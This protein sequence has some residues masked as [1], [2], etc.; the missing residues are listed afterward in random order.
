MP[1]S[2]DGKM[3]LAVTSI[4]CTMEIGIFPADE[5]PCYLAEKAEYAL[6]LPAMIFT[7]QGAIRFLNQVVMSGLIKVEEY[8]HDFLWPYKAEVVFAIRGKKD[9]PLPMLATSQVSKQRYG[10]NLPQS[11]NPFARPSADDVEKFGVKRIRRPDII[12]V[13]DE[14]LRWPGRNATYFDGSVHPDNLKMLIEVKF[15][16]D[17]L[18]EDQEKDY[19]QIA[20]RSRF[21]VMRVDDNRTEEQKQY[22]EVWR[23]FYQPGSQHYKNPVILPPLLPGSHPEEDLP[24]PESPEEGVPGTIPQ[25]LTKNI[26][27]VS[28]SPWSF[29]PSYE[30]WVI[31]GQEVAGLAE[32][33]LDYIRNS[34]RELLAQFGSWFSEA[35]KWVC[36][37]I[38]DPV[39]H[40][41]SYAFSWV[42]E[43]TGKIVTWT[44][45]EIK[46]QWQTVQ[47]GSDIT[48]EELKNIS[49]MQILKEVGEGMLEVVVIIASVAVVILVT[50]AVA[51]AL[52]ALVEILAT[53]ATVSAAALAAVLAILASV[54]FATAS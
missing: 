46:A 1:M 48:L 17:K 18:S 40:Q 16:G 50:L 27:L 32:S 30:D 4:N 24:V 25:P 43:Q 39:T 31:L 23:K 5:D 11:S 34:T 41:V 9:V 47:Q 28:T 2:N 37:E 44:E 19:I 12:L 26:P 7:R 51:A 13:K 36:E 42:S 38:I 22:D 53:A 8:K 29:L 54:T 15:P 35:G 45:S 3:C 52:I 14:A 20:T 10:D 33:G 21:G 49:W 6:R